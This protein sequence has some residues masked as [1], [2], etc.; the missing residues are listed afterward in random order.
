[1]LILWLF[2]W[3]SSMVVINARL[4]QEVD[5]VTTYDVLMFG[6]VGDGK[7]DDTK[8]NYSM[9]YFKEYLF[10]FCHLSLYNILYAWMQKCKV[11]MIKC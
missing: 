1:M 9:K 8:V 3:A 2:F 6:A 7:T 4:S 5:S 11:E 10:N